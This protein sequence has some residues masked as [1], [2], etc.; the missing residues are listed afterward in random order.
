MCV[1]L[2]LNTNMGPG[3][4]L[5]TGDLISG[6]TPPNGEVHFSSNTLI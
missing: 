6:G 5:L 4:E 3:V 2:K 1:L